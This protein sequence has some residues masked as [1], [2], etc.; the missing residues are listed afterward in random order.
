M[1]PSTDWL[2]G[3]DHE[4]D[5]PDGCSQLSCIADSLCPKGLFES[6]F[7]IPH[8]GNKK[9]VILVGKG[10]RVEIRSSLRRKACGTVLG[11][12]PMI[13]A[14]IRRHSAGAPHLKIPDFTCRTII[15]NFFIVT[16][17][18][19]LGEQGIWNHELIV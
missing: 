13:C 10:I 17:D 2:P 11:L 12:R 5:G 7:R 18:L 14:T 19:D 6:S 16:L 3:P 8:D 15:R 4:V 9:S 1:T